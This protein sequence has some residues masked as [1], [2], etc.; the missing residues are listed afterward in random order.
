MIAPLGLS[1][2]FG[3]S[4]LLDTPTRSGCLGAFTAS[5]RASKATNFPKMTARILEIAGVATGLAS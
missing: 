4:G 1:V 3:M 2:P 5:A